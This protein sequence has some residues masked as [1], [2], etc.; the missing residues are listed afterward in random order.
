MAFSVSYSRK[1]WVGERYYQSERTLKPYEDWVR[2]GSPVGALFTYAQC[3][4]DSATIKLFLRPAERIVHVSV[5]FEH[6]DFK[7]L[8]LCVTF[9]VDALSRTVTLDRF[10]C[11]TWTTGDNASSSADVS[12][13]S[14]FGCDEFSFEHIVKVFL[15]KEWT[16]V[17]PMITTMHR[18]SKDDL[19]L[20]RECGHLDRTQPHR[21]LAKVIAWYSTERHDAAVTIQRHFRG[22]RVRMTTTFNPHTRIG[23]F[24]VLQAFIDLCA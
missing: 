21:P 22:W 6:Y 8:E 3:Y 14:S 19:A 16:C 24:Y 9:N 1:E 12:W 7:H 5:D 2:R 15:G 10:L 11:E 17:V 13:V 20:S 18:L 4:K 23:A